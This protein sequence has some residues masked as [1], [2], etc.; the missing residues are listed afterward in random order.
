[1]AGQSQYFRVFREEWPILC[2][3]PKVD[4]PCIY[5]ASTSLQL[6]LNA[7]MDFL[8]AGF[9]VHHRNQMKLQNHVFFSARAVP[10]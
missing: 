3:C 7:I 2:A 5:L 6:F 9:E 10:G 1:M 4:Q 8:N